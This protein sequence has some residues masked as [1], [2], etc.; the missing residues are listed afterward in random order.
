M[1]FRWKLGII[2]A[3]LPAAIEAVEV[4]NDL[5]FAEGRY[6][7]KADCDVLQKSEKKGES[8]NLHNAA[9]HLTKDGFSDGWE[10]YCSFHAVFVRDN[11]ATATAVCGEGS[12]TTLADYYFQ[13][14]D[15]P[16]GNPDITVF[17]KGDDTTEGQQGVTY[18]WCPTGKN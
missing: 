11:S 7:Q 14:E 10:Q 16:A 2:I 18:C 1:R 3:L 4:R 5:P 8:R 9:W 6:A 17:R 13:L 12:L 15:Q